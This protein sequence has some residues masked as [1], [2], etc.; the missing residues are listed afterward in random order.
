MF[1]GRAGLYERLLTRFVQTYRGDAAR[2]PA[3]ATR[4]LLAS[5]AH[6]MRGA[7]AAIGAS[8]LADRLLA[9]EQAAADPNRETGARTLVD[10]AQTMLDQLIAAIDARLTHPTGA[11]PQ[12]VTAGEH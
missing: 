2:L 4:P 3:G 12:G 6:S 11:V 7:C 9:I 1:A 8:R 5:A 10:E